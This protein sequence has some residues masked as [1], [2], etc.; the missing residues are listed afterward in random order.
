MKTPVYLYEL[1]KIS[2][3][4]LAQERRAVRRLFHG[5]AQGFGLAGDAHRKLH[6]VEVE[7]AAAAHHDVGHHGCASVER[8]KGHV[9]GCGIS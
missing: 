8:A 4:A 2:Q 5:R 7:H 3:Q 9:K 1:T 6:A